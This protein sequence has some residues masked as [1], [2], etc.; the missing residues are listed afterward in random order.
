MV[1]QDQQEAGDFE[2]MSK[3][4]C[5]IYD[6]WADMILNLPTEMAGEFAQGIL[7]YAIYGEE[8][9]ADN[10]AIK[11]MLVPIM[12]KIDEDAEAWKEECRRRSEAGKKGMASRWNNKAITEDNT[13]ITNNKNVKQEITNITESESVYEYVSDKEDKDILSD[14]VSEI[15]DYLNDKAGTKYKASTK[16]TVSSIKGRIAEGYTLDDF[17]TVIDKKVKAWKNDPKMAAYLR[18]ETLFRPGHFESYLNEI[19]VNKGSPTKS[20]TFNDMTEDK[21]KKIHSFSGER[22][23][24]YDELRE[25][26]SGQT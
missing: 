12:K 9:E 3:K 8:I 5:V 19:E 13:T 24:N 7:K 22:Q 17:K 23:I 6:S 14:A 11:A 26:I 1:I 20:N 15:V 10:P 21:Y 2:D 25:L 4:S 18:P 16:S